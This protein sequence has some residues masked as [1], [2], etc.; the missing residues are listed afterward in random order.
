M[1]TVTS[2][3]PVEMVVRSCI[4]GK[5]RGQVQDERSFLEDMLIKTLP[6]KYKNIHFF[7][8][9]GTRACFLAE[10]GPGKE[11]RIIKVDKTPESPRAIRHVERGCT[12]LN[13]IQSL[14][15]IKDPE[16]HYLSRLCD[17]YDLTRKHGLT[18]SVE[19]F[20][21]DYETLEDIVKKSPLKK[22]EFER[23]FPKILDA[24]RYLINET[25][26][27]HRDL[28][29]NNLQIKIDK[30]DIDVRITDLAN[31]C[32]KHDTKT[33]YLPTAG[34]HLFMDPFLIGDF[35]GREQAYG[36]KS[37]IYS[38]GK[39]M[40]FSLTGEHIFEFDPDKR[41]AV[42]R[43]T[44]ESLLDEKGLLKTQRYEQ[45]LKS[46][47]KNLPGKVR[48][49][50][51]LIRKCLTLDE[52]Q[53]YNSIDNLVNDFA[54]KSQP[55]FWQKLKSAWKPVTATLLSAALASFIIGGTILKNNNQT[56]HDALQDSNKYKIE[57]A[58]N[59]EGLEISNNLIE[60]AVEASNQKDDKINY[61][62]NN[63]IKTMPGDKLF[64]TVTAN[65]M[66]RPNNEGTALPRFKGAAYIEGFSPQ[67]D[68][69]LSTRPHNAT[70]IYDMDFYMGNGSEF[71][72]IKVPEEIQDGTHILA[73]EL[74]APIE[75][76]V[77]EEN[78]YH[79]DTFKKI[80]FMQP[81]KVISRKRIPLV[82]GDL[83]DRVNVKWIK[84]D[85]SESIGMHDLGDGKEE[86]PKINPS[87]NYIVSI[88]EEGF[89]IEKQ[90]NQNFSSNTYST[91]L[92][93][94]NSTNTDE[95]TLQ[96]VAKD[97]NQVIGYTFVPIRRTEVGD[98]YFWWE[99][100]IPDKDF[101]KRIIEYRKNIY[102]DL[103]NQS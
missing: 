22:K 80:K 61:P 26:M 51:R 23:V 4:P 50:R 96:I 39:N 20:Y 36:E 93:L 14:S 100:S 56:F 12:T 32:N 37:E 98:S 41:T 16:K 64:L 97:G 44:G 48:K 21:K 3:M 74:Y 101:S 72:M 30:S 76:K 81:G 65:E 91:I 1:S 10:W 54:A 18:M 24:V 42:V 60:F 90:S 92:H 73:V 71:V 85:Y 57:S 87:L 34:G 75:K 33:K 11:Q 103:H 2:S 83:A 53:R 13:D 89:K 7:K 35:T 84:L 67:E 68:L 46:S 25:D 52:K 79:K 8:E 58:W 15:Q 77:I 40:Y 59:G 86:Y 29:S 47:I 99:L 55:G 43:T 69:Y 88:V 17:Y 78:K 49:Y 82:I 102:K 28:T 9:G 19:P 38:L 5:K 6:D 45:V 70:D 63:F 95:R 94:P 27:Y 66:P 31:A 62:E